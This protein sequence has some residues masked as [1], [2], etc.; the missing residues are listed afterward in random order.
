MGRRAWG[1]AM[2]SEAGQGDCVPG[3]D[4]NEF[5]PSYSAIGVTLRLSSLLLRRKHLQEKNNNNNNYGAPW[6]DSIMDG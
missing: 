2:G 5:T 4:G 1:P 3:V 6:H